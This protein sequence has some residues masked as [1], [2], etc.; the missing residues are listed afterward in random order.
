MKILIITLDKVKT[1]T[2]KQEMLQLGIKTRIITPQETDEA[3]ITQYRM[4]YLHSSISGENYENSISKVRSL[5]WD[6]PFILH[7]VP[8]QEIHNAFLIPATTNAFTLAQTIRDIAKRPR[9][10]KITKIKYKDLTLDP[11]RRT[12]RRESKEEK[13]RNKEFNIIEILMM[14]PGRT[15]TKTELTEVLW[16]RNTTMLSNTLQVHM[17]SLRRKIDKGFHKKLIHTVPCV[18]YRLEE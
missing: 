6:I 4:V 2:L 13:L 18:G 9:E 16:D 12:I 10:N 11:D 14:N 5:S 8:T 15:V 7:S 1:K 17:S 3:W